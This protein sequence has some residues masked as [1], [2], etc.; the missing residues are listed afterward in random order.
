MRL[1]TNI[2]P[3]VSVQSVL[4]PED[5]PN[6][7]SMGQQKTDLTRTTNPVN[8]RAGMQEFGVDIAAG[9]AYGNATAV[10]NK[11]HKYSEQWNTLYPL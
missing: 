8:L 9:K 5:T 10:Y 7:E 2:L 3:T 11:H 4:P 6:E 1:S